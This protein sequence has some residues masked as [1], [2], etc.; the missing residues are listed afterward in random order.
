M[1]RA[2][3]AGPLLPLPPQILSDVPGTW[4]HDTMSRRV[5]TDVLARLK[6]DNAELLQQSHAARSRL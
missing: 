2:Q 1:A 3:Q 5:L 6:D 4:A